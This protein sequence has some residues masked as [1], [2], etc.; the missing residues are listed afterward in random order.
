MC[1]PRAKCM[2]SPSHGEF[3][4]KHRINLVRQSHPIEFLDILLEVNS[5][6]K[7]FAP[8]G[9]LLVVKKEDSLNRVDK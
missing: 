9:R 4:T 1:L 6:L 3:L 8:R 5:Y 7:F 2:I